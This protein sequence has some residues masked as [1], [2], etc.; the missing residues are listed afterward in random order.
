M[1]SLALMQCLNLK[2]TRKCYFRMS[3]TE[4]MTTR[5][6]YS[7][8]AVTKSS[9]IKSCVSCFHSEKNIIQNNTLD[10]LAHN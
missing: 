5:S 2:S 7:M 6:T 3:M 1:H 8:T 9:W 4:I 10:T